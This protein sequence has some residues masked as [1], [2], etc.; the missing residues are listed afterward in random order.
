MSQTNHWMVC[1]TKWWLR[2]EPSCLWETKPWATWSNESWTDCKSVSSS[3]KRTSPKRS[4]SVTKKST[5]FKTSSSKWRKTF[6]NSVA[7]RQSMHSSKS[8]LMLSI[9]QEGERRTILRTWTRSSMT[10]WANLICSRPHKWMT[11]GRQRRMRSHRGL[12][13]CWFNSLSK[14][15]QPKR[16]PPLVRIP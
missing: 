8:I 3:K 11:R 14:P 7:P 4:T 16:C 2:C 5:H 9:E 1:T 10:F 12:K 13:L 6:M 15:Q